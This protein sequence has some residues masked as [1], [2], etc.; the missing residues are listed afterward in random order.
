MAAKRASDA[1][2]LSGF[3]KYVSGANSSCV[4]RLDRFKQMRVGSDDTLTR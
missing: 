2:F 1:D 3:L 4:V